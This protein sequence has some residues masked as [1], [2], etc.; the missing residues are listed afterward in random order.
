[1]AIDPRKLF[2][3]PAQNQAA[4]SAPAPVPA[5]AQAPTGSPTNQAAAAQQRSAFKG[6]T[7]AAGAKPASGKSATALQPPVNSGHQ[8]GGGGLF[9]DLFADLFATSRHRSLKDRT[10]LSQYAADA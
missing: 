5:Q 9:D 7:F 8:V 2:G 6:D 3:P 1:M 4:G 10:N